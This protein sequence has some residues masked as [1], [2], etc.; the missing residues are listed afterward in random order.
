MP[1]RGGLQ[2]FLLAEPRPRAF[3]RPGTGPGAAVAAGR[4]LTGTSFSSSCVCRRGVMSKA[5]RSLAAVI[6]S[7]VWRLERRRGTSRR[8]QGVWGLG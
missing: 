2:V 1:R 6:P 8:Q 3:C 5:L 7:G 4:P